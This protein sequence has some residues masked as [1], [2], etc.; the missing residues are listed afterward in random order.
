[1]DL[2]DVMIWIG[3]IWPK[4]GKSR[5]EIKIFPWVNMP[6]QRVI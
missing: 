5:I 2:K 6:L 3:F 4:T 1:M